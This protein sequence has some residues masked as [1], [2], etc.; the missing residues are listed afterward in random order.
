MN[1]DINEFMQAIFI[2]IDEMTGRSSVKMEQ[3][4]QRIETLKAEHAV[5]DYRDYL[6]DDKPKPVEWEHFE[7]DNAAERF[8]AEA[9][10]EQRLAELQ[11]RKKPRKVATRKGS[12]KKRR[13]RS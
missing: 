9:E 4:E 8:K 6:R 13:G 2:T 7:A 11:G 12:T 10:M 5:R 3:L 1:L